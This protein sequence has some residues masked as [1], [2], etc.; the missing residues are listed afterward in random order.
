VK[1]ATKRPL[2]DAQPTPQ[3]LDR[4][5]VPPVASQSST[6]S[7]GTK[8]VVSNGKPVVLNSDSDTDSDDLLELDMDPI[9]KAPPPTGTVPR[10]TRFAP[11]IELQENG[12]RKPSEKQ[13]RPKASLREFVQSVVEKDKS[14]RVTA[15]AKAELEKPIEETPPP[16][17]EMTEEA[18]AGQLGDSE[19]GDKAK[20]ILRAMKRTD[21][22]ENNCVFHLFKEEVEPS[23]TQEPTFPIACL[24]EQ[25]WVAQFEGDH[26]GG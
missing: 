5:S 12:L 25:G 16:E 22:L 13:K 1:Q 15:E 10:T 11:Y 2:S 19:D 6:S 18:V 20:R 14:E 3:T 7:T 23:T 9:I 26:D 4:G 21:A 24:P 8:R 17:F